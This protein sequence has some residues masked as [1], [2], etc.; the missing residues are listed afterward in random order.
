LA[1]PARPEPVPSPEFPARSGKICCRS[2]H[3]RRELLRI[4]AIYAAFLQNLC[5]AIGTWL[6]STPSV[7]P[8]SGGWTGGF[9]MLLS[10]ALQVLGFWLLAGILGGFALGTILANLA[11]VLLPAPV[12]LS[13]IQSKDSKRSETLVNV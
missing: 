5:E 11:T 13:E 9:N 2:R 1:L 6:A 4:T 3:Y 10:T 12:R 7:I 8:H